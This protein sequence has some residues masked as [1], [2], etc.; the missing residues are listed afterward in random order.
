MQLS[1]A[2]V[3]LDLDRLLSVFGSENH[4]SRDGWATSTSNTIADASSHIAP[5]SSLAT[6]STKLSAQS[7]M[8]AVRSES[9][10]FVTP[11]TNVHGQDRYNE[12]DVELNSSVRGNDDLALRHVESGDNTA[13]DDEFRNAD[14]CERLYYLNVPPTAEDHSILAGL[15]RDIWNVCVWD[16]SRSNWRLKVAPPPHLI[17]TGLVWSGR[18]CRSTLNRQG[19]ALLQRSRTYVTW[20]DALRE[21]CQASNEVEYL[22]QRESLPRCITLPPAVIT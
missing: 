13:P 5:P 3:R 20:P 14:G 11:F 2:A 9:D 18:V 12:N 8:S 21:S 1:H 16:V 22:S 17:L 7:V 15:G 19:Q 10:K 4:D 6:P